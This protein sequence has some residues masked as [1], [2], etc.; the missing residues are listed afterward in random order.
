MRQ[1]RLDLCE[2]HQDST[3]EMWMD[4]MFMDESK[5][6]ILRS[7]GTLVRRGP[8]SDRYDPKYT[9]KTVKHPASVMLGGNFRGAR[10]WRRVS[11]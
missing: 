6:D 4:V 3:E 7:K 10:L 5:F 2:L 11:P 9:I 1:K 8:E